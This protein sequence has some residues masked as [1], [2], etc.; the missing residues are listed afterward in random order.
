MRDI[1]Y[2]KSKID[3][4]YAIAERCVKDDQNVFI[5]MLI[6]R[7]KLL[8]QISNQAESLPLQIK[9]LH[10]GAENVIP[11]LMAKERAEL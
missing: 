10:V 11:N 9:K 7:L 5:Q 2:E 1:D 6:D 8:D 4:V 3:F